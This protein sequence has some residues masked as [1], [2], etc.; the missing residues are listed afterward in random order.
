MKFLR[1]FLRK[2]K[3]KIKFIGK[4]N[5]NFFY[6]SNFTIDKKLTDLMNF[7]GSDKGGLND[8]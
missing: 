3:Y 5:N 1:N 7:Y 8:Q 4:L 2:I 6:L